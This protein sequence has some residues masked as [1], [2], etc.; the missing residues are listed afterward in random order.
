MNSGCKKTAAYDG[1][2]LRFGKRPNED[3]RDAPV[4]FPGFVLTPYITS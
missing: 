1:W 4:I 2:F 3:I